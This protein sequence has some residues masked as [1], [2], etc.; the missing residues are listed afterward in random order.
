MLSDLPASLIEKCRAAAHPASFLYLGRKKNAVGTSG[1]FYWLV[2]TCKL[3]PEEGQLIQ[4]QD[5]HLRGQNPCPACARKARENRD[6]DSFET[7][8]EKCRAVHGT[9]Y[10]YSKIGTPP[11][12]PT[13]ITAKCPKG[14]VF[15]STVSNHLFRRSGC[16]GCTIPRHTLQTASLAA[17]KVHGSRY[18]YTG[19]HPHNKSQR[20][21]IS[22]ICPEHGA[23]T[24]P[25]ST[26]LKGAGC[27]LCG[28]AR[29]AQAN[30]AGKEDALA[31]LARSNSSLRLLEETYAY[32]TAK[33]SFI[34]PQGH[35]TQKLPA[36]LEYN[37]GCLMCSTK[38]SQANKDIQA[39]LPGSELEGPLAP[40]LNVDVLLNSARLV[41]E[42]HGLI[43]HS[44]FYQKSPSYHK[45]RM[46]KIQELG[47]RYLQ[48]FSDEWSLRKGA[49]ISIILRAANLDPSSTV[50]ARKT[51]PC[52]VSIEEA[53]AF[54]E[55][56]HI[57]GAPR[58]CSRAFGLRYQGQLRA[59]AT[60][61]RGASSRMPLPER[62]FEL[63]RFATAGRLPGGFSKLLEYA[64]VH[65]G[66]TALRT[67]SDNRLF[68]GEV[69][70]RWGFQR[71][72]EI[73]VDYTYI[74]VARPGKPRM[75]KANFQKARLATLFPGADLSLPEQVLTRQLGLYRVYDAGKVLWTWQA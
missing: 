26:H 32:G 13:T 40:R 25:L 7:V 28:R 18:I 62:S 2:L 75:H 68:T 49:C 37:P 6:R 43:W 30:R 38:I 41:V 29:A 4:R 5:S 36:L 11:G 22:F 39:L 15:T 66:V 12:K 53:A 56:H 33:A 34:C 1:S 8:V 31:K 17:R 35:V 9:M 24:Q 45:D 57:Q 42:H 59:V 27:P 58:D 48:I 44:D 55:A 51:I 74:D 61:T 14:H 54:L 19:F 65:S 20:A 70:R 23:Q 46:L 21:R 60:L 47:Y 16:P 3:H 63:S 64:V 67:I 72:S 71:V 10:D 69:Y 50:G 52:Q 73:P